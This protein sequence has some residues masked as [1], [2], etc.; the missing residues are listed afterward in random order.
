MKE[1]GVAIIAAIGTLLAVALKDYFAGLR[2]RRR[3]KQSQTQQLSTAEITDRANSY[4]LL[5]GAYNEMMKAERAWTQKELEIERAR[6]KAEQLLEHREDEHKRELREV[7]LLTEEQHDEIVLLT[8]KLAARDQQ[9]R[10]LQ[11]PGERT[12]A[13]DQNSDA[14]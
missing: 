10:D 6:F 9:I 7:R 12:I 2:T 14:L 1:V 5:V 13:T 3:L 4:Q 8:A 11:K